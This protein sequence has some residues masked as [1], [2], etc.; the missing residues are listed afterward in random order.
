MLETLLSL[1]PVFGN[2][3]IFVISIYYF[4]KLQCYH[5][6]KYFYFLALTTI[7]AF[8]MNFLTVLFVAFIKYNI[9]ARIV[10]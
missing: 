5:I 2:F 3:K 4:I 6:C 7:K 10:T 9:A 8:A 1:N